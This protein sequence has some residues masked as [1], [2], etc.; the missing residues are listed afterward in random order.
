M[1]G[2][3]GFVADTARQGEVKTTEVAEDL[4]D[5]AKE[6]M[7][8]SAY[9]NAKNTTQKVKHTTLVSEA[10]ENV[11][12]TSEYRSIQELSKYADDHLEIH[13]QKECNSV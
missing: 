4:I 9:D 11:V 12:D 8:D 2:V 5:L 7:I 6:T 13:H 10:D 1:S 3:A